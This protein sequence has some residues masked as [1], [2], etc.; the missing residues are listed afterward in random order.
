MALNYWFHPPSSLSPA[1]D[2]FQR[3]YS[4][5]FLH[6]LWR[7]RQPRYQQQQADAAAAMAA[8]GQAAAHVR[9]AR[10]SGRQDGGG[11]ADAAPGSFSSLWA[12][13][14]QAV[15]AGAGAGEGGPPAPGSSGQRRR[16]IQWAPGVTEVPNR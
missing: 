6:S 5:D 7:Q 11:S 1:S 10:P 9:P 15:A 4:S 2:G 8:A 12:A 13:A 14:E 16:S 3:P